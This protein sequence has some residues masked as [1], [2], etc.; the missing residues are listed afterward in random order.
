MQKRVL[1]TLMAF[2]VVG[3]L[4]MHA[5]IIK[6]DSTDSGHSDS[7]GVSVGGNINTSITSEHEN[8][9][10]EDN[11]S[12]SSRTREQERVSANVS[13][14][15][16][17]VEIE[18]HGLTGAQIK[19]LI[20]ERNRLRIRANNSQLPG[21]CSQE[22]ETMKCYINGTRTMTVTAGKSGN[23][24]VQVQGAN[25]STNVTLYKSGNGTVYG[26]FGNETLPVVLPDRIRERIRE[27]LNG[28]ITNESITLGED[29]N[30]TAQTERKVKVLGIFPA[31]ERVQLRLNAQNGLILQQKNPWWAF[32]ASSVKTQNSVNVSANA[33]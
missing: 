28:T 18:S 25:M 21:N 31:Q 11:S 27:R 15:G 4:A 6:A 13:I 23:T 22:G 17:E 7:V 1:L 33:S 20:Q 8:S 29:G 16:H 32:L 12:N 9:T 19:E 2:V 5:A 14:D 10:V 26:I 24:I 30:Y 3:I